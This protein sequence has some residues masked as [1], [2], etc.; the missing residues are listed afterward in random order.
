M[1]FAVCGVFGTRD[2]PAPLKRR[3]RKRPWLFMQSRIPFKISIEHNKIVSG[4]RNLAEWQR[5]G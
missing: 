1:D 4:F 3:S 5:K 2:P